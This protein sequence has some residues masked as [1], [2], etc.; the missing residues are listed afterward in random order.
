MMTGDIIIYKII[1]LS[2]VFMWTI[3]GIRHASAKDFD[4]FGAYVCGFSVAL[5]GGTIRDILLG[6]PVFWLSS[7]YYVYVTFIAFFFLL[8]FRHH[9]K[10]IENSWLVFDTVGLALFVIAGVDKTMHVNGE[11]C[12]MLIPVMMGCITGVAGG[13]I[14]DMFLNE[15]PLI[16]RKEIYALPT[17]MGGIIYYL[18]VRYVFDDVLWP[19]IVSFVLIC[20]IRFVVIYKQW[21]LPKF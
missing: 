21:N 18:G 14:R 8:F 1:E 16:F 3:S 11:D 20:L 5:G 17:I 13:V 2:G 7:T 4:M 19:S 10:W 15:E 9:I 12:G 6:V